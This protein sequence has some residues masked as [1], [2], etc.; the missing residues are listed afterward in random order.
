MSTHE[1]PMEIDGTAEAP[2]EQRISILPVEGDQPGDESAC[3]FVLKKEGHTMSGL[4]RYIL[5]RFPE[6]TFSGYS[7]PHPSVDE[8][9]LRIETDGSITPADAF[10]RA[11]DTV[12]DMSDHMMLQ[13]QHEIQHGKYTFTP[14]YEA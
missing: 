9:H 12:M 2:V 10:R 6:V 8:T 5:H 13:F 1:T 14:E 3:T 11:L 4:L 7:I